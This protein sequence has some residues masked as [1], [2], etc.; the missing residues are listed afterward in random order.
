MRAIPNMTVLCPCD[1]Y[2]MTLAVRALLDYD[3][4]VYMR[5]ARLATPVFTDT[6]PGYSFQLGR[7]V[8]LRDG[9]DVTICAT[10]MMVQMALEAAK[11]LEAQGIQARVLNI[12]TLKPLDG[13]LI[14]QAARETGCVVTTEEH[15]VIGG[16]GSAVSEYLSGTCPVPVVRHGVEDVFGRSGKAQKVLEHFG[17][18]AQNIADRAQKALAMKRG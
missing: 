7:G 3:G 17:L 9:R 11:I 15:S 6:L 4:P 16:L 18:T 2:E 13:D 8:T 12:H 5:S 14:L 1:G 10:G